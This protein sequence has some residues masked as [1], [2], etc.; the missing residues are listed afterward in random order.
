MS[1]FS[2]LNFKDQAFKLREDAILDATTSV[3]ATKGFDLMNSI[4][5][6]F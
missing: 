3:L 2:K 6:N 4:L 1:I 5:L